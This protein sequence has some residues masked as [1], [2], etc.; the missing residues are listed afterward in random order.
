MVK[1]RFTFNSYCILLF[2]FRTKKPQSQAIQQRKKA[3][4]P[5]KETPPSRSQPKAKS[6]GPNP[7][8]RGQ[9]A[10]MKR[11]RQKYAD[12]DDEER[13][14]RQQILQGASGKLSA[15]HSIGKV[16]QPEQK[17]EMDDVELVERQEGHSLPQVQ[18][19]EEK[20]NSEVSDGEEEAAVTVPALEEADSKDDPTTALGEVAVLETLTGQPVAEDSLLFALPFCA[21]FSALQKF[22]YKAK[23]LPGV[24][25][26]GESE[27][28]ISFLMI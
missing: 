3:N 14:M 10:K 16:P 15:V 26:K 20:E 28:N 22:K 6:A 5:V 24:Q 4:P 23:L 12:Q 18:D 17:E 11:I 1:F 21:P 13:Q 7:L 2:T 9:K 19:D 8:K 25:K 27:W